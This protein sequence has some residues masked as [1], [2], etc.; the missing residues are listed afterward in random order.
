M[1]GVTTVHPEYNLFLEDVNRNRDAVKG[2]RAIK[3]KTVQYLEPLP[4]MCLSHTYDEVGN[5]LVTRSSGLTA[6]GRASYNKYISLAY[7]YNATGRTVDG[8]TGLIFSKPANA[9]IPTQLEYIETNVDGKGTSLRKFAQKL[10]NDSF[11]TPRHAV[12]VDYPVTKQGMSRAQAERLNL[13]PKLVHYKYESIRNWHFETIN[14]QQKLTLCVLQESVRI[15]EDRF[16][17]KDVIQYRVLELVDGVYV[18]SVMDEKDEEIIPQTPV[19]VNDQTVDEIPLYFIEVGSECK[20]VINDLVDANLNHYRFFA[21]YAAK[22]HASAFP[23][24]YETGASSEGKNIEIGPGT[25]WENSMSDATFGVLQAN[26]DGGSMRTYLEDMEKR[27]AALGAEMLKPRSAMAESA[28]AK[29]LDQ[30][31][32][33]S[34][35]ADVATN[36]SEAIKK[37]LEF[38]LRWAGS[39][40]DVIYSLNTDYDPS[41]MN[42]QLLTALFNAYQSGGI[43][44]ET[45]Y[46]NLQKGEIAD[47]NVTAGEEQTRITIADSGL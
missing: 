5:S 14:N 8:L 1:S 20:S 28:E 37:A 29:S 2:E 27:M 4:S 36:V 17:F 34:T 39:E 35:T 24:F 9:E 43:S 16:K 7:F 25:K 22:E 19:L 45:F 42:P 6:E 18:Q 3:D 32:Q 23:I 40:G 12:M 33:N 21:D 47:P 10:V 11:I 31:A 26:G 13:R 44:F 38:A 30:V 46:Q 15:K 41:G